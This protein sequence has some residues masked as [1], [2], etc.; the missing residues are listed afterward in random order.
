MTECTVSV[1]SQNNDIIFIEDNYVL[2]SCIHTG[3][4]HN[5]YLGT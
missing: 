2:Q 5:L 4:Q 3:K 1:G